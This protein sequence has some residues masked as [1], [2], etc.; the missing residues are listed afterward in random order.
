MKAAMEV[1]EQVRRKDSVS[2]SHQE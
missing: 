1:T 2:I